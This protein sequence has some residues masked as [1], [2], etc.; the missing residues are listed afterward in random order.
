[1]P[2]VAFITFAYRLSRFSRCEITSAPLFAENVLGNGLLLVPYAFKNAVHGFAHTACPVRKKRHALFN[3]FGA[4]VLQ[5][6]PFLAP[7]RGR[8]LYQQLR[9]LRIS[10]KY[11]RHLARGVFSRTE[12]RKRTVRHRLVGLTFFSLRRVLNA[13]RKWL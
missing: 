2:A 4:C 11:F 12:L 7:I 1:M 5:L 8:S 3:Q 6:L 13:L 9:M 10:S